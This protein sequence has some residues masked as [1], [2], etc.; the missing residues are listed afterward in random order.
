[1]G[2]LHHRGNEVTTQLVTDDLALNG[3]QAARLVGITYR[4]LDHWDTTGVVAPS[5]TKADG[6]GSRRQY[7][8]AD[9]MDLLVV[10][11]L[12]DFG[13]GF[14]LILRDIRAEDIHRFVVGTFAHGA[15]GVNPNQ[16]LGG[17]LEAY[18]CI[19]TASEMVGRSTSLPRR[20][21]S[22]A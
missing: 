20:D 17:F 7:S 12:A 13:V 14:N 21:C 6:Q 15:C 22:T 1:Q 18:N 4:Q 11:T 3:P 19:R 9:L 2:H 10:K 5:L 8:Y 16:W